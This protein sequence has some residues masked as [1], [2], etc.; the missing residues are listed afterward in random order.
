MNESLEL[1]LE[2]LLELPLELLPELVLVLLLL[3]LLIY[4]FI[5]GGPLRA[6]LM[7]ILNTFMRA[8]VLPDRLESVTGPFGVHWDPF[9]VRSGSVRGPF[10]IRSGS[11]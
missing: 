10:G 4:I 3:L 8:I 11:V 9:G 7:L 1:L 6:P 5:T 2:L